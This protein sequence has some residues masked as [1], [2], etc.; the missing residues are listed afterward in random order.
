MTID[1]TKLREMAQ[2]TPEQVL[3]ELMQENERLSKALNAA[4]LVISSQE[5]TI[6]ILRDKAGH[7]KEAVTTLDS[8]REAN[9]TLTEEIGRLRTIEAAA[10]NL[11]KVK[12]RHHSE[13]AMNQLLEVLG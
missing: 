7:G 13:Q 10:R 1:T 3:H 11:A 9:A 12:G 5:R 2:K 4:K 8:E 6:T